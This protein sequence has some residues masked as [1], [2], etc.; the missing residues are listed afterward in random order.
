MRTLTEP[1]ISHCWK[2]QGQG[3]FEEQDKPGEMRSHYFEAEAARE[4]LAALSDR[5]RKDRIGES[6]PD[7][8]A[9]AESLRCGSRRRNGGAAQIIRLRPAASSEPGKDRP[10]LSFC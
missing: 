9:K 2:M 6:G 1:T 10:R 5:C 7:V 4:A 8:T 3:I